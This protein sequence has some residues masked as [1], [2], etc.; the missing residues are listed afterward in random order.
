MAGSKLVTVIQ[1]ASSKAD[2]SPYGI[3]C[4][5]GLS[6][7]LNMSGRFCHLNNC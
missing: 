3:A 4:G 1:S 7:L 6:V 2:F 5:I